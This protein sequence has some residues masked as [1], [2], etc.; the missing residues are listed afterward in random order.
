M[1]KFISA[2][3]AGA[4]LAVAAAP[5]LAGPGGPGPRSGLGTWSRPPRACR[6]SAASP[7][8]LGLGAPLLGSP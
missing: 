8:R 6:A 5:A 3:V 2:L 1:K 7:R 4:M